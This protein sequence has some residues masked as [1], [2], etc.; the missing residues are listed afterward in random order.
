[1]LGK[2][3]QEAVSAMKKGGI[4]FKFF[5]TSI[6]KYLQTTADNILKQ[7]VAS[8]RALKRVDSFST[9][10]QRLRSMK[11][12]EKVRSVDCGGAMFV[13]MLQQ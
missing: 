6:G 8:E 12:Q 2:T 13:K 3:L 1:M 4:L 10:L 7:R 5:F 11:L 9:L